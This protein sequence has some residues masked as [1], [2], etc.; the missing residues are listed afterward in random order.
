MTTTGSRSWLGAMGVVLLIAGGGVPGQAQVPAPA[1]I[2]DAASPTAPMSKYIYGQFIE[3]LGRCIYGGIW[4]EMLEDRKFF[5]PVAEGESPWTI[6][7][8]PRST[9]MTTAT[10]FVG[11]HSPEFELDGTSKPSG[12]S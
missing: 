2:V 5:Y 10:A 3:H 7:G 1:V 9:A 11:E 6:L 12:I 4:A 8:E